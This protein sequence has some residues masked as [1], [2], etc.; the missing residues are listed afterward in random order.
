MVCV[1]K[2][3]R[4]QN[5]PAIITVD[6]RLVTSVHPPLAVRF[7]ARHLRPSASALDFLAGAGAHLLLC[8]FLTHLSNP[9]I[10]W[11]ARNSSG[12]RI[13][14]GTG[15]AIRACRLL[16]CANA[17]VAIE[18][19]AHGHGNLLG[20]HDRLAAAG[21]ELLAAWHARGLFRVL[22]LVR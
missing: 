18:R 5:W 17:A 1:D 2:S 13:P 20:R 19:R 3:Q 16:V 21:P 8:I 22:P 11:A 7:G 12:R 15:R 6:E 10:D 4:A 9:R 14:T